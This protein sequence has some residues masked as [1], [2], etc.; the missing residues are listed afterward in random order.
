M[1]SV[2]I[3]GKKPLYEKLNFALQSDV[4]QIVEVSEQQLQEKTGVV[5]QIAVLPSDQGEPLGQRL[6]MVIDRENIDI[7]RDIGLAVDQ[8]HMGG[9]AGGDALK[10]H[11]RGDAGVGAGEVDIGRAAGFLKTFH[12]L[13]AKTVF[14][15]TEGEGGKIG[16]VGSAQRLKLQRL[17]GFAEILL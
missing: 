7:V 1:R 17:G 5:G 11:G 15:H 6:L 4:L 9:K 12:Q 10:T 14:M 13:M 3:F 8:S 16:H 2:F